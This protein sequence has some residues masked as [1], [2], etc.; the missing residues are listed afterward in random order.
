MSKYT[1][2][3]LDD[4]VN[5]EKENLDLLVSLLS[6]IR[7]TITKVKSRTSYESFSAMMMSLFATIGDLF[8]IDG[9]VSDFYQKITDEIK[10]KEKLFNE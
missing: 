7:S 3:E 5:I 9:N 1:K 10:I 8:V 6:T 2:E 4:M